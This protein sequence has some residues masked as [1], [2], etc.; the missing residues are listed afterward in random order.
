VAA[1]ADLDYV[2][3][4]YARLPAETYAAEGADRFS[5]LIAIDGGRP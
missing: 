4:A 5:P 3:A 1:S 2:L